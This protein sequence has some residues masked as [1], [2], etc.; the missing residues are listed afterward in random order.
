DLNKIM[1]IPTGL[2][3]QLLP[4]NNQMV[5]E[6]I[7]FDLPHA[8]PSFDSL[9]EDFFNK[10][11]PNTTSQLDLPH[12]PSPPLG[13]MKALCCELPAKVEDSYQSIRCIHTTS[14]KEK[15]YL[16]WI[17]KYWEEVDHVRIAQRAWMKAQDSL[18]K[19]GNTWQAR[20]K[21]LSIHI[22]TDISEGLSILPWNS[23]LEG[24]STS[25][26]E[27]MMSLVTYTGNDWLKDFHIN[28]MLDL[29]QFD[30]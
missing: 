23:C 25:A 29:L 4:D 6:L 21:L 10:N 15:T 22:I 9:T 17:I 3:S 28:Q 26:Q 18:R 19:T 14:A 13:V 12:I 1:E 27:D 7:A 24:F 16:L 20:G 30:L 8:I 5:L 11:P 2:I